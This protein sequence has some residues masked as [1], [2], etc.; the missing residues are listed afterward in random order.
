VSAR[1]EAIQGMRRI[2]QDLKKLMRERDQTLAWV[3]QVKDLEPRPIFAYAIPQNLCSSELRILW[4]GYY[5]PV[6]E[7]RANGA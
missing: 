5:S 3:E 6:R 2:E 7:A 1:E 4:S